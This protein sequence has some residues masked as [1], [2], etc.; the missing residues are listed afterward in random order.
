M[1][2]TSIKQ[3]QTNGGGAKI[4]ENMRKRQQLTNVLDVSKNFEVGSLQSLLNLRNRRLRSPLV[5]D[6][7]VLV[8]DVTTTSRSTCRIF[9]KNI[10]DIVS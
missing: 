10:S 2:G 7:Q 8:A 9:K 4:K 1:I 5:A 3:Q 6:K